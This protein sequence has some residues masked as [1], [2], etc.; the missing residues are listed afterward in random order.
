M[1]M[2]IE[3][4]TPRHM[5][6]FFLNEDFQPEDDEI[7]KRLAEREPSETEPANFLTVGDKNAA[8]S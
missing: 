4:D 2:L 3:H 7:G 8:T 6:V 1:M 5:I